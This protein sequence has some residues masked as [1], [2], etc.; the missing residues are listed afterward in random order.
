MFPEKSLS[1]LE[2]ALK[3]SIGLEGAVDQLLETGNCVCGE[4]NKPCSRMCFLVFYC[5]A[6]DLTRVL[7]RTKGAI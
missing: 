5:L 6:K 2:L 7:Q 1:V 4:T 3:T